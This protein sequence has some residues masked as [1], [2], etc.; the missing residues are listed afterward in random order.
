MAEIAKVPDRCLAAVRGGYG[1]LAP[2]E[3]KVALFIMEHPESAADLNSTQLAAAV[4]VSQS[5]VV[6]CCLLMSSVRMSTA[7]P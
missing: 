1:A 3:Q 2:A 6:K 5:T 7:I 4:G